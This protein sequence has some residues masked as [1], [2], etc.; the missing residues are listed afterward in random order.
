VRGAIARLVPAYGDRPS[1]APRLAAELAVAFKAEEPGA[2]CVA[3]VELVLA[4]A[5]AGSPAPRLLCVLLQGLEHPL[6]AVQTRLEA[7]RFLTAHA[8]LP[9]DAPIDTDAFYAQTKARSQAVNVAGFVGAAAAAGLVPIGACAHAMAWIGAQFKASQHD[10]HAQ[11]L[12]ANALRAMLRT[13]PASDELHRVA[14]ELLRDLRAS[15]A[16]LRADTGVEECLRVLE[17]E[18]EAL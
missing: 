17:A 12:W 4:A 14:F 15:A 1:T 18:P 7:F 8:H 9:Y 3:A 13:R 11:V 6:V 2:A 16:D 10:A 5:K